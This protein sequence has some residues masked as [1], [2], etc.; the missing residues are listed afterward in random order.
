MMAQLPTDLVIRQ[1]RETDKPYLA[2]TFL[3]TAHD[4]ALFAGTPDRLYFEPMQRVFDSFLRH[5]RACVAVVV[6]RD[7]PEWIIAWLAA[8]LLDSASV[9]WYAHTQKRRRQEGICSHLIETL[10][11]VSKASVFTSKVGHRIS[12]KHRLVRY[13]TLLFEV[14]K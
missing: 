8:W 7:D 5:P 10:P 3:H 12:Q 6:E 4:L 14:L 1:Y 9:V 11:G 13:P 2:S